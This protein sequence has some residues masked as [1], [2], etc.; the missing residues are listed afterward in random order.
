MSGLVPYS[1]HLRETVEQRNIYLIILKN[2][3]MLKIKDDQE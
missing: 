3:N 2:N 1:R